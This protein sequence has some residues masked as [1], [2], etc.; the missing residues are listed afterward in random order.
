M[1]LAIP[2]PD[3]SL[4][5]NPG[6]VLIEAHADITPAPVPTPTGAVPGAGPGA[7]NTVGAGATAAL[8]CP[9]AADTLVTGQTQTPTLASVCLD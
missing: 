4:D 8:P 5:Q 1:D 7:G 3:L 2:G 6:P 9:T